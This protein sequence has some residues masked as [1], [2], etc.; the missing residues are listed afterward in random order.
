M[1]GRHFVRFCEATWAA[2]I[3]PSVE[4]AGGSLGVEG[5]AAS[6]VWFDLAS[7][8]WDARLFGVYAA[9]EAVA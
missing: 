1:V 7:D 5:F 6:L 9:R 4:A 2:P 8:H 3:I